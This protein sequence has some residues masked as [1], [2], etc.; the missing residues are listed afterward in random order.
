MNLI[1][2]IKGV[3][4]WQNKTAAQIATV[5]NALSVQVSDPQL[6]T[7]AGVALIAGPE[8]AEAFRVALESNGM[9][10]AVH[11]LGGSGLQLSNPLTQAALAAFATGFLPSNPTAQ[12]A[13]QLLKDTGIYYISPWQNA[14]YEGSVTELAVR[15][16]LLIEAARQELE[17]RKNTFEQYR[18]NVIEWNGS[19]DP[20]VHGG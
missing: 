1:D 9:G 4:D 8:G 16:E 3:D 6:Y 20:P 18:V 14:G 5:L 12:T 10:W 15:K 7:W 2:L 11:Q 19:G 13:A 17:A